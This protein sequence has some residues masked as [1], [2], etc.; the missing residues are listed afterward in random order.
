MASQQVDEL[1]QQ[2]E[3]Q[4]EAVV[5]DHAHYHVTH[6]L[7]ERSGTFQHLSSRHDHAHDH[8]A[9]T[10]THVPH[11]EFASEHMGETHDHDHGE[12]VKKRS[13][14]KRATRKATPGPAA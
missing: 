6:N 2:E 10:H 4:H 13:P 1:Q 7:D 9:V 12:P 3:H 8:A 5:H 14:A 11:V